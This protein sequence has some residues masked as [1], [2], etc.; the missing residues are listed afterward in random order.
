MRKGADCGCAWSPA[1]NVLAK[2]S[3][4]RTI[5]LFFLLE[6]FWLCFY[7]SPHESHVEGK[8]DCRSVGVGV[9]GWSPF[10]SPLGVPGFSSSCHAFSPESYS[11][12]SQPWLPETSQL[13][14]SRLRA[15]PS[16]SCPSKML[17]G[18]GS[19]L[20]IAWLLSSSLSRKLPQVS[21]PLGPWPL[22]LS[23]PQHSP[24][25]LLISS[26]APRPPQA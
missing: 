13:S 4:R 23:A 26:G 22:A 11:G 18:A 3:L 10:R 20:L 9:G 12:P 7:L 16:S 1:R 8:E 21:R 25:T 19:I 5:V 24:C 15:L 6:H 17:F 14:Q 2:K